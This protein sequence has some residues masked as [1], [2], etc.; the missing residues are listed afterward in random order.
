M[1]VMIS[2]LYVR[3]KDKATTWA[4]RNNFGLGGMDR[5]IWNYNQID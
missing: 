3:S 4:S 1:V 5:Q 2:A